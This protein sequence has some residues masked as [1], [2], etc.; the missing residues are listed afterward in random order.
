MLSAISFTRGQAIVAN[1]RYACAYSGL[2]ST[3]APAQ[4]TAARAIASLRPQNRL[5]HAIASPIED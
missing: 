1:S 5:R 3:V 4:G 2:G